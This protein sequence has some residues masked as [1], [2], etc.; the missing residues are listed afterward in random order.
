[1]STTRYHILDVKG[2]PIGPFTLQEML[3]MNLNENT[4]VWAPELGNNWLKMGDVPK[5]R[6]VLNGIESRRMAKTPPPMPRKEATP[7]PLPGMRAVATATAEPALGLDETTQPAETSKP[8]KTTKPKAK[9][10]QKSSAKSGGTKS[11]TKKKS[12][13]GKKSKKKSC[14]KT[15]RSESMFV[16][17]VSL[18]LLL[19]ALFFGD[20]AAPTYMWLII[21][22]I[23]AIVIAIAA[24][25]IGVKV[26]M[27]SDSGETDEADK[28]SK[29]ANV[30]MQVSFW[31]MAIMSYLALHLFW[32]WPWEKMQG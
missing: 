27:L 2:N 13:K 4:M 10:A 22:G 16:A 8:K 14:D 21:S 6:P 9:T 12:K 7:P 24:W 25:V 5:M 28:M 3:N 17:V 11:S 19:C 18:I 23:V 31:I 20:N 32:M 15:W 30:V 26:E 29:L 1:M